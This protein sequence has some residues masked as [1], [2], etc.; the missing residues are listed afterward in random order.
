MESN[1]EEKGSGCGSIVNGFGMI[2]GM[3]MVAM[4]AII[5]KKRMEKKNEN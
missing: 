3:A 2:F 4:L 5:N 1:D